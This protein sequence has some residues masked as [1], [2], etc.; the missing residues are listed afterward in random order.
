MS[1][2]VGEPPTPEQF[3]SHVEQYFT[4]YRYG[5]LACRVQGRRVEAVSTTYPFEVTFDIS[6]K[7]ETITYRVTNTDSGKVV[8]ETSRDS[9]YPFNPS[10]T[11]ESFISRLL[12]G[13]S[14]VLNGTINRESVEPRDDPLTR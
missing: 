11:W 6:E 12:M 2:P 1:K 10:W 4:D 5:P 8:R 9:E 13:V 7:F 14:G 3:K